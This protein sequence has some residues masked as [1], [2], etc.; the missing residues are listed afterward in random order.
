MRWGGWCGQLLISK[1]FPGVRRLNLGLVWQDVSHGLS[2]SG[3]FCSNQHLQNGR[4]LQNGAAWANNAAFS[5][6]KGR[7]CVLW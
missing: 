7:K 4:G 5:L 3:I 2:P 6:D 1:E